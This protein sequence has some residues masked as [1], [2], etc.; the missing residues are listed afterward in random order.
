MIGIKAT[1]NKRYIYLGSGKDKIKFKTNPIIVIT[2]LQSDVETIMTYI[3]YGCSEYSLS[4]VE[5]RDITYEE[6]REK[7]N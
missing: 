4:Q 2:N 5:I 1:P 7:E 3:G 6:A